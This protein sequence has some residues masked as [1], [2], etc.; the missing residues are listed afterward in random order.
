MWRNRVRSRG[1]W[2]GQSGHH[3]IAGDVPAQARRRFDIIGKLGREN[4][5]DVIDV[6]IFRD[7]AYERQRD[8][9]RSSGIIRIGGLPVQCHGLRFRN[10]IE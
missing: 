6:A 3:D 5:G 8:G 2:R 7:A 1:I 9:Y 10:E 4:A